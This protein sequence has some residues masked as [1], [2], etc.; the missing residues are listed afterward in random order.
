VVFNRNYAEVLA[1]RVIAGGLRRTLPESKVRYVLHEHFPPGPARDAYLKGLP[2]GS[3]SN[4]W[5]P[6]FS[7][8]PSMMRTASV[9]GLGRFIDGA[10]FEADFAKRYVAAGWSTAFFDAVVCMHI[11]RLIAERGSGRPNAYELNDIPQ[12]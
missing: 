11:G 5:W 2:Q 1:Q 3:L 6:H 10:G 8:N 9:R 7:L 4:A 12:F